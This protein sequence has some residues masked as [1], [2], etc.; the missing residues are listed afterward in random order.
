MGFNDGIGVVSGQGPLLPEDQDV[1]QRLRRHA[2]VGEQECGPCLGRQPAG[3]LAK[4]V[5]Q[6][7]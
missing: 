2:V 7:S 4:H 1:D 5:V 3:M 6:L